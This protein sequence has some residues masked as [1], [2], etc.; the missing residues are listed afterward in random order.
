MNFS[1]KANGRKQK[2]ESL[3]QTE[4][5]VRKLRHDLDG[6]KRKTD[7]LRKR[8]SI[9]NKHKLQDTISK[10]NGISDDSDGGK[11]VEQSRSLLSTPRSRTKT[12]MKFSRLSPR[13][14]QTITR[15]LQ[16]HEFVFGEL[17]DSDQAII[18][19]CSKTVKRFHQTSAL[20]KSLKLN[21][22]TVTTKIRGQPICKDVNW[23]RMQESK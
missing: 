8:L 12:L 15:K 7:A 14:H 5:K 1:T 6:A 23:L 4:S 10:W 18:V 16:L 11:H 21:R 13:R 3:K 20:S 9:M 17:I 2:S 22:H 19:A